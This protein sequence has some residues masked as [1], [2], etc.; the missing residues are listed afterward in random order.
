MWRKGNPHALLAEC[1]LV[2]PLWNTVWKFL[3]KLKQNYYMIQQFHSWVFI[4]RKQKWGEKIY[5]PLCSLQHYL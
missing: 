1:K 4:Q 3:K 2:Q 5:T